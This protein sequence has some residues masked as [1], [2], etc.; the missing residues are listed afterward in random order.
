MA[1]AQLQ[2]RTQFALVSQ[3]YHKMRRALLLME[4]AYGEALPVLA[5]H[6]WQPVALVEVWK[7]LLRQHQQ[8]RVYA[9]LIN[10]Q[11]LLELACIT[12]LT[13][14]AIRILGTVLINN[15][16][17][18]HRQQLSRSRLQWLRIQMKA[19]QIPKVRRKQNLPPWTNLWK[20][21]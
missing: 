19:A 11:A 9:N 6:K 18:P 15:R 3:L 21:P 2:L 12:K 20:M 17:R 8:A 13:T 4:M 1:D 16:L 14:Q 5:R 10:L 7:V